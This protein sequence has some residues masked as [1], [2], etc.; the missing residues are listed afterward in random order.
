MEQPLNIELP[1]ANH[2]LGFKEDRRPSRLRLWLTILISL[3]LGGTAV[4]LVAKMILDDIRLPQSTIAWAALRR[5]SELPEGSPRIW[6]EA[7]KDTRWPIILGV[8]RDEQGWIFFTV[9][10]RWNDKF[11]AVK[12]YS[13]PLVLASDRGLADQGLGTKAAIQAASSLLVHPAFAQLELS[14][15]DPTLDFTLAGPVD[16]RIWRTNLPLKQTETLLPTDKEVS[17]DLET[18]PEAWPIVNSN[19]KQLLN[20]NEVAERPSFI[21]WTVAS[22]TARSIDLGYS[23]PPATST[24]YNLAGAMGLYDEAD[25]ALPDGS[26]LIELR[27]PAKKLEGTQFDFNTPGLT[28]VGLRNENLTFSK[29]NHPEQTSRCGAGKTTAHFSGSVMDKIA[30]AVANSAFPEGI[31]M[32][33]D[34]GYLKICF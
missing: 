20:G 25:L 1:Q 16:G 5:G 29:Q 17:L 26:N 7:A 2:L 13:G 9:T 22:D 30:G 15:L 12:K 8:A 14:R 4:F 23:Q 24:I 3:M 10:N 28:V 6:R 31:T 19:L 11:E 32:L 34:A 33:E 21:S 27:W 18:W